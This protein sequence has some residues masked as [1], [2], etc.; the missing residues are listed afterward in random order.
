V[1]PVG[2]VAPAAGAAVDEFRDVGEAASFSVGWNEAARGSDL[3]VGGLDG[4]GS[5][6]ADIAPLALS[7]SMTRTVPHPL[8]TV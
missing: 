6:E 5:A 2:L 7:A 3:A 8:P 1:E 4:D